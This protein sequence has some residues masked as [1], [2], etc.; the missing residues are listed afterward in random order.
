[1]SWM[2]QTLRICSMKLFA[3]VWLIWGARDGSVA[4]ADHVALGSVWLMDIQG[5]LPV[6]AVWP[7]TASFTV[8]AEENNS[9]GFNAFPFA[10]FCKSFKRIS[11]FQAIRCLHRWFGGGECTETPF[12]NHQLNCSMTC[13][14]SNCSVCLPISP[15]PNNFLAHRSVLIKFDHEIETPERLFPSIPMEI[16][17]QQRRTTLYR[18]KA[19]ASVQCV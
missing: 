4:C 13:R 8:P 11:G 3:H 15:S 2:S 12:L 18:E 1:M 19:T 10:I 14:G 5:Q 6:I 7:Y 16:G 17:N 9:L